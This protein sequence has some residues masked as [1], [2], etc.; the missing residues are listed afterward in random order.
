VFKLR[1]A[2]G[3]PRHQPRQ[4]HHLLP[5]STRRLRHRVRGTGRRLQTRTAGR[6]GRTRTAASAQGR[7]RPRGEPVEPQSAVCRHQPRRVRVDER[8][9]ALDADGPGISSVAR[10]CW[11]RPPPRSSPAPLGGVLRRRTAAAAGQFQP[12]DRHVLFALALDPTS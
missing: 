8:R 11:S 12:P 7:R 5:R 4:P 3:R 9:R 2:A 1:A 6:A 10:S